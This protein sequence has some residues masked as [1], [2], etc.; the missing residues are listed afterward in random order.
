MSVHQLNG[1][2][3]M[4]NQIKATFISKDQ[5]FQDEQTI[6]WFNVEGTKNNDEDGVW[7]V[8]Q[9]GGETGLVDCDG[10]PCN[11]DDSHIAEV[12]RAC[13]VTEEMINDY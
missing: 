4:N 3:E 12:F 6:Y 2:N 13:D 11:T 9:S 5:N 7:G 8:F 1:E 10:C